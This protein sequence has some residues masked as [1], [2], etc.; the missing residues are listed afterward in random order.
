MS[1]VNSNS[2]T[3]LTNIGRNSHRNKIYFFADACE[4]LFPVIIRGQNVR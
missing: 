2:R 1:F 4:T 3:C